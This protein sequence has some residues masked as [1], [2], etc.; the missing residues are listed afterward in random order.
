M[1]GRRSIFNAPLA[2]WAD[3]V[4]RSVLL[5]K[6]P[7]A[8]RPK[9]HALTPSQVSQLGLFVRPEYAGDAILPEE[10]LWD[11]TIHAG[12]ARAVLVHSKRLRR[13]TRRRGDVLAAVDFTAPALSSRGVALTSSEAEMNTLSTT[14]EERGYGA[15][16]W[17]TRE[18]LEYFLFSNLRLRLFWGLG[19]S[20]HVHAS[21]TGAPIPSV[22]VTNDR[23]RKCRVMNVSEFATAKPR[24]EGGL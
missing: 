14:A 11:D 16:F 18:E 17:L 5:E 19:A 15:P 4:V 2:P 23:G 3:A 7:S 1:S 24:K 10:A 20:R 6:A 21:R 22:E 9:T 8:A 13:I 12:F